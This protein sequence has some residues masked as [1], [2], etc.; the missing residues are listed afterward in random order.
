MNKPK[1][2]LGDIIYDPMLGTTETIDSYCR[3][4]G[5]LFN[6]EKQHA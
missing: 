3:V 6:K 2:K 1:Y 5:N 4:I